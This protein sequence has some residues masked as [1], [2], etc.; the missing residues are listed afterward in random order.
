LQRVAGGL[1]RLLRGV[2]FGGAPEEPEYAADGGPTHL[3]RLALC[4]RNGP[5]SSVRCHARRS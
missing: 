1:Q 4:A 3:Q 5:A 2:T